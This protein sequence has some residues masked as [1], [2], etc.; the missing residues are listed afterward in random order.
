MEPKKNNETCSGLQVLYPTLRLKR[1]IWVYAVSIQ[2]FT[3]HIEDI[4]EDW[5]EYM[6]V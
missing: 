3:M 4:P 1:Y 5:C 2:C 6:R